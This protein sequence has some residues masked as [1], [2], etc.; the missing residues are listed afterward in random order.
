MTP[1]K[2]ASD[3]FASAKSGTGGRGNAGS[4]LIEEPWLGN[5]VPGLSRK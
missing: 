1:Q 2:F 5:H 4:F 3:Y